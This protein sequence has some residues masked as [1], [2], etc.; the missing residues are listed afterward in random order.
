VNDLG[1]G[2]GSINSANIEVIQRHL[3][4]K[5]WALPV[6]ARVLSGLSSAVWAGSE[7]ES[8]GIARQLQAGLCYLQGAAFNY[9]APF[10][11]RKKSGS[12]HEYGDEG[13]HEFIELK[14]IQL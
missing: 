12:G 7:G 4:D 5:T 2:Q 1:V 6:S 13:V 8:M 9:Q 3:V 10:G 14:S 11:G